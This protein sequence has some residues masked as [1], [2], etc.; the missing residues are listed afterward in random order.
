[1]A[2]YSSK[3]IFTLLLMV[4]AMS[5]PLEDVSSYGNF[6]NKI[7]V[8]IIGC[9]VFAR[10]FRA[11]KLRVSSTLI[12]GS[13]FIFWACATIWWSI[14]QDVSFS[15]VGTLFALLT[16]TIFVGGGGITSR[17]AQAILTGLLFGG[18]IASVLIFYTTDLVMID[19]NRADFG[20][21]ADPNHAAA[22][23]ILAICTAL[24]RMLDTNSWFKKLLM[25]ALLLILI[26]A[27]ILLASRGAL[28]G[29]FLSIT[30]VL[31]MKKRYSIIALY[32]TTCVAT[33]LM[34]WDDPS[35]RLSIS[36]ALETKGA[37]RLEIWEV[38]QVFP[39]KYWLV[40]AGISNF[41]EVFARYVSESSVGYS[42]G[43]GGRGSHNTL[44]MLMVEV[45][46]VGSALFVGF[47]Y[48]T[49]RN[50]RQI[51][52][53]FRNIIVPSLVGIFVVSFFLDILYRKYFWIILMIIYGLI[54]G[55]RKNYGKNTS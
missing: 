21:E 42:L 31:A 22:S 24:V 47:L 1:M 44:L 19:L 12:F 40:G 32:V 10:I 13:I 54:S 51:P 55:M 49:L 25:S 6:I 15:R 28:L 11:R 46:V 38:T 34:Y 43:G 16:F 52:T 45:G 14:N 36:Y 9:F 35:S 17:D 3:K 4:Y 39:I 48:T 33:L 29:L 20:E 41:P 23:L 27:V 18:V 53:G 50:I 30:M 37:H 7:I 5:I 26:F 8:V 2:K